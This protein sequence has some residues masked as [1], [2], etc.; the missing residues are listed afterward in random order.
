MLMFSHSRKLKTEVGNWIYRNARSIDLSRWSFHFEHG[1]PEAVLNALSKYQ[2]GDGGFGHALEADSW[3]PN[4]SPIQTWQA[5]EIIHEI[6]YYDPDTPVTA[7]ILK[8][9]D[10]GA[11]FNGKIWRCL[12]LS[13]NDYPHA[14][15]WQAEPDTIDQCTYNPTAALAGF[16]LLMADHNSELYEKCSQI[17]REAFDHYMQRGP[18][19]DMHTVRCYVRLYEY[20]ELS[21]THDVI[22]LC[23]LCEKLDEDIKNQ[24]DRDAK[25]WDTNGYFS[26]P[27]VFFNTP[28]SVF[29]EQ[30]KDTAELE[31]D[32]IIKTQNAEGVWDVPWNW[33]DYPNEWIISENWWKADIAV[34]NMLYLK[35]FG[36]L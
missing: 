14:S 22:D 2:N 15:W 12:V 18:E 9:L 28:G 34:K 8:Y 32:L 27:S 17:A 5:T 4:S 31:C 20:C 35:N 21:D 3:N 29:C 24:I 36:R 25:L 13:N 19:N 1:C 23:K 16:G 6:G 26:R 7:G 11:D 10:S 33:T 30:N